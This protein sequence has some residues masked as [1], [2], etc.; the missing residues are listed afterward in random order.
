MLE[1]TG[2]I[3]NVAATASPVKC[4]FSVAV[5]AGDGFCFVFFFFFDDSHIIKFTPL[6][7]AT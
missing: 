5:R 4:L 2:S 6:N 7:Y 1:E 3:V